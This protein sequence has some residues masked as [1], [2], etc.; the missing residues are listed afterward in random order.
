[1]EGVVGELFLERDPLGDVPEH[2]DRALDALI[3]ADGRA[4]VLHGELLTVAPREGRPLALDRRV[5]SHRAKRRHGEERQLGE[6]RAVL[7]AADLALQPAEE[8]LGSRV[9]EGDVADRVE[10]ADTLAEA[11]GDR[12]EALLLT[13]ALLV[14]GRVVERA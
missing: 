11:G 5:G 13:P 12:H 1:M 9:E 3:R 4:G 7:V 2:D 6:R 10:G 14:Q 8:L